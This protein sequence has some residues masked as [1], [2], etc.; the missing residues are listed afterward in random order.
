MHFFHFKPRWPIAALKTLSMWG[1][2]LTQSNWSKLT[3]ANALEKD[4]F[5]FVFFNQKVSFNDPI[6][7]IFIQVHHSNYK[8]GI[9]NIEPFRGD[10][11]NDIHREKLNSAKESV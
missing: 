6:D 4:N 10:Y 11:F 3:K 7:F 5:L 2:H 8:V 9:C 1:N